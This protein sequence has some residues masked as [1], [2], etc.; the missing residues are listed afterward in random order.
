VIE[1]K[2]GHVAGAW[3]SDS[4]SACEMTAGNSCYA[5]AMTIVKRS[6]VALEYTTRY[7]ENYANVK[8]KRVYSS[9]TKFNHA[10]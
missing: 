3:S 2:P 7:N 9:N 4:P 6:H 5:C 8:Y 10:S 1:M